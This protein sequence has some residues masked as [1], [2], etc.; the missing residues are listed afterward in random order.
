MWSTYVERV[1]SYCYCFLLLIVLCAFITAVARKLLCSHYVALNYTLRMFEYT[2]LHTLV[3][4]SF[5]ANYQG[6]IVSST[7]WSYL[8]SV[9]S[10][11]PLSCCSNRFVH[12]TA[13]VYNSSTATLC[14]GSKQ[15]INQQKV[16]CTQ[17]SQHTI[18]VIKLKTT[19]YAGQQSTLLTICK[20]QCKCM[21]KH[22]HMCMWCVSWNVGIIA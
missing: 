18:H 12:V 21:C 15:L 16:P 20:A 7:D 13:V 14:K 3:V 6:I 2:S 1:S 5:L 17:Q 9:N 19:H 11:S 4:A 22:V 10:C 8:L